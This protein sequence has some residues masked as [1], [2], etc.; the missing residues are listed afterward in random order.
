VVLFL[1][2]GF[3]RSLLMVKIGL[4]GLVDSLRCRSDKITKFL[5]SGVSDFIPRAGQTFDIVLV[6]THKQSQNESVQNLTTGTAKC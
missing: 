1:W 3:R 5:G 4:F 2:Y 6:M